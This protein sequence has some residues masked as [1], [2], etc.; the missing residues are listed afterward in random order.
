MRGCG[1]RWIGSPWRSPVGS[2][3]WSP[4][5][6][7]DLNAAL[8]DRQNLAMEVLLGREPPPPRNSPPPT[9]ADDHRSLGDVAN[10]MDER[11]GRLAGAAEAGAGRWEQSGGFET[12]AQ[13]TGSGLWPRDRDGIIGG[14]A[15][16]RDLLIDQQADR[17]TMAQAADLQTRLTRLFE[18]DLPDAQRA[19]LDAF[20]T[21]NGLNDPS[22]GSGVRPLTESDVTV[23]GLEAL[24]EE[25]ARLEA[26]ARREGVDLE[27]PSEPFRAEEFPDDVTVLEQIADYRGLYGRLSDQERIQFAPAAN[28]AET[29]DAEAYTNDLPPLPAGAVRLHADRNS[30]TDEQRQAIDEAEAAGSTVHQYRFVNGRFEFPEE[31]EDFDDLPS[32]EVWVEHMDQSR[33]L[34]G[35]EFDLTRRWENLPNDLRPEELSSFNNPETGFYILA[36]VLGDARSHARISNYLERNR[37]NPDARSIDL[38]FISNQG[39]IGFVLSFDSL[40]RPSRTYTNRAVVVVKMN[41]RGDDVVVVTSYPVPM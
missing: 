35:N 11:R 36:Q 13:D 41:E 8:I 38:E 9:R 39:D 12:G 27:E 16:H 23:A 34:R 19:D 20:L 7:R 21:T 1:R 26:S 5:L 31:F 17:E 24:E 22:G 30:L 15:R 37:G 32:I 6:W 40:G 28:N 18:A 10:D 4:A 3:R 29:L 33:H 25:I 14:V 2:G